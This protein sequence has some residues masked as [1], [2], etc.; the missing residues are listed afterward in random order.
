MVAATQAL[1]VVSLAKGHAPP[2][3]WGV[4]GGVIAIT[5]LVVVRQLV[6]FTDN[7]RLLAET[8][9]LQAR[10]R[11]QATHDPLTGLANRTLFEERLRAAWGCPDIER[12][13]AVLE[14]DLDDFKVINDTHGHSAGDALLVAVADR[15][16]T[17]VRAGDTVARLGG[18]EF[19]VLL[20]GTAQE[21]AAAMAERPA[22]WP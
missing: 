8:R 11:H 13:T 14:V 2:S 10:L 15:L 7:S 6:A 4:L 9:E 21:T 17:C 1:M 12:V 20:P 18:D 19:A 22:A 5:S 3:S 16:R